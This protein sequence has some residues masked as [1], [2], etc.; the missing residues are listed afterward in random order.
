MRG[1][2]LARCMLGVLR[3]MQM[4]SVRQVRVM[5]SFFVV[6]RLVVVRCFVVMVGGLRVMFGC[7]T[8][9]ICG[10][11][12]HGFLLLDFVERGASSL[13]TL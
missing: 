13:T 3:R 11:F 4:V 12:R 7:L 6:A 5:R 2:V 9:V 1:N 10:L 8:M